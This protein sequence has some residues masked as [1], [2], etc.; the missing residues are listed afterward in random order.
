MGAV[1]YGRTETEVSI[2]GCVSSLPLLDRKRFVDR[3]AISVP[4]S[5]PTW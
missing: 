3:I 4:P 5:M 2:S 1:A